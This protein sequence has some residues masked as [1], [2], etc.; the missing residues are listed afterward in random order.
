MLVLT[1]KTE[2][3]IRIGN[4]IQIRIVKIKGNSVRIGIE[5]PAEVQVLRGELAER[6][7]VRLPL[8]GDSAATA[9]PNRVRLPRSDSPPTA[10]ALSNAGALSSGAAAPLAAFL[11]LSA[12]G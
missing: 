2:E 5:A 7:T 12:V 3:I 11:P 10:E 8:S 1:R 6:P 4:D 9:E